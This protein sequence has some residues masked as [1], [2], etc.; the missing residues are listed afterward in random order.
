MRVHRLDRE[1]L[2]QR[3]LDEVFEFLSRARN[4]EALT[5]AWLRF[6]VLTPEPI[7][8]RIGTRINYRL[9][10]RGIPLRWITQI[11][12]WQ[13]QRTFVDRMLSGPYSLWHH[14]HDFEA[15]DGGTLVADHVHYAVPL[16]PL[17]ELAHELIVKRDLEKIFRFREEAVRSRLG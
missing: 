3:P 6:E 7:Q 1:Q 13:H 15:R 8:M 9:H 14:R 11:E 12:A 16:G 4:L 5:P 2:I 17:G 10:F